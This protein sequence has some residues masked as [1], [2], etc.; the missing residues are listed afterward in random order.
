[1]KLSY[2]LSTNTKINSKW[3]KDLNG[4]KTKEDIWGQLFDIDSG[5]KFLDMIPKAQAIKAKIVTSN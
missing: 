3:I 5:N 1:M 4:F 2:N